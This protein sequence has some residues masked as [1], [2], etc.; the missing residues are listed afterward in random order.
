MYNKVQI[1][2]I[3]NIWSKAK[4][5]SI[6]SFATL[7]LAKTDMTYSHM[8]CVL[9]IFFNFSYSTISLSENDQGR[10]FFTI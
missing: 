3:M 5:C 4:A 7:S 8:S 2:I 6:F 1:Y 10:S 9:P